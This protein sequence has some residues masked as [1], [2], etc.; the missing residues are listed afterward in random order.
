MSSSLAIE[1]DNI[2]KLFPDTFK[3]ARKSRLKG[4]IIFFLIMLYLIVGFFT[5]D[6]VDIP[7]KWKPQNAAMFALDTY[8]HK[9]HV[10]MKWEN[11]DDIKIAFEGN[12]RSVYG[13]D[14]LDKSIPDWFY[15]NSDNVGNVVEFN[16]KGKAILYKDRVEIVNFPKYERDFT[17]KL[18]TNG[19]PYLVGSEDLAEDDLKG[20]RITENRVE[21]RPTLYERI[22]VYPRKVEIHRYSIGW[23]YFWFDFSSPLEPYSFFEA[24][25]LTF[26]KER[27]VPE[28]S[29]LKLFFT[30]IKDNEAFM[31]G[32]VWWAMLETIVMAVL[33]TMFATV[34]ALPLSFLAAYN[35]TPIKALR[36]TLRR[37]F[38]TLR[39]IDFL[40]W[41]LIFLRAFGP[42]PF[43]GIFAIG[44]TDTGTLGKLYSE[45]IENTE[46]KQQEGVQSTGASKFLQHRFGIIPQ[47]LPIFV[48]QSLYYLESNTRGAVIIGAMG[49]GGIGLQFLGAL[50]TGNDFENV[51]YMAILV[52][53]V[54]IFMDRLSAW[55]R[56]ILIGSDQLIV[57]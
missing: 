42:G 56:R 24:L 37:L 33:G 14:N 26:S 10:T 30:E 28:M 19:K 44:F 18:N 3:Q 4:Q 23:K 55:L 46:K 54:V 2:R 49:A 53:A 25:G 57:R 27:V 40:I 48:S 15:K 52:L 21:F 50:G 29:N 47:I 38:D 51:A 20:F 9:D 41:S 12:Y 32:R 43:T 39:G 45:A 6:V 34:M 36:F 8:A 1:R 31:H 11:H 13:R 22:Q 17:I 5:L 7:K 35:V 16:N